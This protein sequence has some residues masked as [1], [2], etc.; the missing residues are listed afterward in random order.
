MDFR[1]NVLF[2]IVGEKDMKFASAIDDH[3]MRGEPG[4]RS[5]YWYDGWR[6]F[7][8]GLSRSLRAP[9]KR[10]VRC[11]ICQCILNLSR[12]FCFVFLRGKDLLLASTHTDIPVVRVCSATLTRHYVKSVWE[13]VDASNHNHFCCTLKS[14]VLVCI[15]RRIVQIL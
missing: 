6:S 12:F 2:I 1:L 9:N 15:F 8:T 3:W 13:L 10:C 14:R 5:N 4:H 7:R 11:T